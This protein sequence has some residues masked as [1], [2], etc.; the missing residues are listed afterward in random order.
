[1]KKQARQEKNLE[2][3]LMRE[4]AVLKHYQHDN[5]LQYIGASNVMAR[6]SGGVYV[7]IVTELTCGGDLLALLLSEGEVG[8]KFRVSLLTDAA[9]A[10]EFLH[11]R[12]LIHRDI[13]SPNMLIDSDRRCKIA[14]FGMARQLGANMTVVGTGEC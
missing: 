12:S 3:Y 13:K 2:A 1:I 7:F 14:D 4:L 9:R 8:W 10:L 11:S 6:E 5:L